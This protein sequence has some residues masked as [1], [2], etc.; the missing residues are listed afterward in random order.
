MR[1]EQPTIDLTGSPSS[2]S[3]ALQPPVSVPVVQEREAEEM[4][5]LDAATQN[6]LDDRVAAF[7]NEIMQH[8]PQSDLFQ[9]RV[10]ALHNLGRNEIRQAANAANRLL[11]RPIQ[12]VEQGMLDESSTVG[13]ALL[14]LRTTVE[15][16]DPGQYGDLLAP[17]KLLGFIPLGNRLEA[18]F[19]RYQASQREI[20]TLINALYRG[21]DELR[22]D[23]ATVE[24]EKAALWEMIE[25]LQQY[26]YVGRQLDSALE[27]QIP[28]LQQRDP[29]KA[30]IV[31]EELLFAVRRQVQ[32]LQT[33]LA[34]SIQGYLALDLV[35]QNNLELIK[36]VERATT[37]MVAALR[38]AIIVAQAVANQ[39][40]VL[41]Q[42]AALNEQSGNLI[43]ATGNT[44]R[45]QGADLHQ[46]AASAAVTLDQLQQA[47][48]DVYAT[49]DMIQTY[50]GEALQAMEETV[51][52]LAHEVERA[53]RY[54]ASAQVGT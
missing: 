27:R 34:V 31:Q 30:R 18:Y 7:L 40:L 42:I 28:Q 21:Q 43:T 45:N 4:V 13:R 6:T 15:T 39:Q 29:N 23:N 20:N 2:S 8:S 14:D 49:M 22:K 47:F 37:T 48:Q 3:T 19:Y 35:R 51:V 25:R 11:A 17:R 33:Q 52:G 54:L 24:T 44:L 26:V 1:S 38:T 50:K 5:Q 16:L 46:Q 32:D 41:D 12:S 36:G 53:Q 9:K 10:N